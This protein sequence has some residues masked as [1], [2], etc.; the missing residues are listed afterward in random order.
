M[1]RPR[2]N[3][4]FVLPGSYSRYTIF[5]QKDGRVLVPLETSSVL[6][7]EN[8]AERSSSALL[9]TV[10]ENTSTL[11]VRVTIRSP[12]ISSKIIVLPWNFRVPLLPWTWLMEN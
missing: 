4:I 9:T 3:E 6:P 5:S 10:R 1:K 11:E 12:K 7:R 2:L 8:L